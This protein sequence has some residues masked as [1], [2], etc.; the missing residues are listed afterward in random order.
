MLT[1]RATMTM[2]KFDSAILLCDNHIYE[3]KH[4]YLSAYY[5]GDILLKK[6]AIELPEIVVVDVFEEEI[7]SE[8]CSGVVVHY[9]NKADFWV[10]VAARAGFNIGGEID[11]YEYVLADYRLRRKSQCVK[12]SDKYKCISSHPAIPKLTSLQQVLK[13]E[14]TT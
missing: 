10:Q 2:I 14:R 8:K 12:E 4:R 6:A 3:N 1:R 9:S 7:E 11:G 13:Y 5:T